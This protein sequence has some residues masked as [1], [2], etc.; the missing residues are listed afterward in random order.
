NMAGLELMT[1]VE[2]N[3]PVIWIIFNDKEFKLIKLYQLSTYFDSALVEFNNPDYVA[4]AKACGADGYRVETLDEFETAFKS[5]IDSGKPT[6]IDAAITRL[7]LPHYSPS[8]EG[9]LTGIWEML[10]KRFGWSE[11][12]GRLAGMRE[13]IRRRFGND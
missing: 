4:Y 6:I 13:N 7:A 8:P 12:E 3:L 2:Y 9:L 10:L 1:A 5:A 11:R